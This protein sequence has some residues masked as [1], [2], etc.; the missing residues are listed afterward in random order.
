[1]AHP[2][3]FPVVLV[4]QVELPHYSVVIPLGGLHSLLQFFVLVPVMAMFTFLSQILRSEDYFLDVTL[5][6]IVLLFIM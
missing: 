4:L 2:S 6:F 5:Q 3:S 1:V